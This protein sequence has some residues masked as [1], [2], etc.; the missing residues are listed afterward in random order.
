M[1]SYLKSCIAILCIVFGSVKL[2]GSANLCQLSLM[3]KVPAFQL[4]SIATEPPIGLTCQFGETELQVSSFQEIEHWQQGLDLDL[5]EYLGSQVV[6]ELIEE[7]I[8]AYLAGADLDGYGLKSNLS[9]FSKS[10]L[11]AMI[12]SFKAN[13]RIT[14]Q[15]LED[16]AILV[17]FENTQIKLFFQ[18]PLSLEVLY[19]NQDKKDLEDRLWQQLL[20][21]DSTLPELRY[22]AMEDIIPYQDSLYVWERAVFDNLFSASLFLVAEGGRLSFVDSVHHPLETLMNYLLLPQAFDHDVSIKLRY[23]MYGNRHENIRV[24]YPKLFAALSSGMETAVLISPFEEKSANVMLIFYDSLTGIRHVLYGCMDLELIG[25]ERMKTIDMKLMS[26][27]IGSV[28]KT[29]YNP[30]K[31]HFEQ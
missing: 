16:T 6:G 30:E 14:A 4:Q 19:K 17:E 23:N 15:T 5:S 25:S 9:T 28:E 27:I 22:P 21:S 18:I 29:Q 13:S 11:A 24:A 3:Q 8:L 12:P 26:H 1:M 10:D 7:Y 31:K 20:G 2:S